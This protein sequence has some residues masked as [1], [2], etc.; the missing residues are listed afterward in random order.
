MSDET[1]EEQPKPGPAMCRAQLRL[2]TSG[3]CSHG[4]TPEHCLQLHPTE[5]EEAEA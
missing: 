4:V 3:L 5:P 2:A 1:H